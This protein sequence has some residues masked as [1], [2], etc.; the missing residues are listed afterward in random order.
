MG[1][2]L[3]H[4]TL[5][6][7]LASVLTSAAC[8]SAYLVS[9]KRVLLFAFL[10]FL[11]YFFDVAWVLQDELMY[12]GLD[13]QMT[14]AYLMVRSYASILAGAGFLVS[15]WLVVCTVLGEKS[16]AL[17]AVPGV[18]F[19]VA[20]AVV[21]IVFPEGNVQ[22]FTF[23]T[24][25]ALLLFWMLGFAA[26]RYRTTDDSVERGRLRRHLRLYVALWVLGVLVVAEDVLFFLVVDP[27]TLGIGPWAFTSERNYAENA[28]MLVCMFV[29]CRDA[30]RT[31]ALCFEH[32]PA[33]GGERREAVLNDT[34]MRY[35]KQHQLSERER[36]V[37]YLVLQGNDN[38]NI[39]SSLQLS[40]STV[41]VH[42]HN[43]L[44]KSGQANR[45]E[46]I[47]DFWR[48]S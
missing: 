46:L 14:S 45:Q 35:G 23:Y 1:F 26:Y 36:E 20:S 28:L 6:V 5:I 21:L 29:A 41:K 9:R 42:V 17:M 18:V 27:A 24:L 34:L 39:A 43:I 10:A 8:L 12:P 48:M 33:P 44:Q 37:L 47:R 30:F 4:F 15:F 38:Q 19:V 22:R 2:V 11:F 32:P 40:P 31:L 16:R 7:L 3:F 13:A 25:R